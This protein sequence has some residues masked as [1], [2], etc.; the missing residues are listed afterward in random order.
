LALG[1]NLLS[2]YEI[3][4]AAGTCKG[5][6]EDSDDLRSFEEI[7]VSTGLKHG[8]FFK[9]LPVWVDPLRRWIAQTNR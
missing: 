1:G 8:A 9:P 2:I 6:A 3:S 4:D 7:A 5:L